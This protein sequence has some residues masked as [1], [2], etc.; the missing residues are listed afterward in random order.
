MRAMEASV[1]MVFAETLISGRVY[2]A[3]LKIGA[4][5][6]N[7]RRNKT[8]RMMELNLGSGGVVDELVCLRRLTS[9]RQKVRKVGR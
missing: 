6:R 3:K 4:R 1:A 7:K 8:K 9:Y 2:R 5:L